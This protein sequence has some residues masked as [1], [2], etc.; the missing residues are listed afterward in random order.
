[1]SPKPCNIALTYLSTANV[2]RD[3]SDG[4]KKFIKRIF[5]HKTGYY[6]KFP[7]ATPQ[8]G[9]SVGLHNLHL[10]SPVGLI[11]NNMFVARVR[12]PAEHQPEL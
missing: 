7:N 10:T 8:N 11:S 6:N 4:T 9:G 12:G 5:C 1:M 3:K 2:F